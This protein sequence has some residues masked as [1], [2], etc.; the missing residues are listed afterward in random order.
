MKIVIA[1]DSFKESLSSIEVANAIEAGFRRVFPDA[2]YVSLPVADGGEGTAEALIYASNGQRKCTQV[3]DPIFR[4]VGAEWGV[5][6]NSDTAVIE[7]AAASGLKMLPTDLRN[8]AVTSSFGSGELILAGLDEGF[9]HFIIGLGGSASNDCGAGLLSALGARFL[10]SRGRPVRDGGYY[11]K[12]V[13]TVDLSALDIRLKDCRF[14]IA[15]DVDNT[16]VGEN[17][18]SFIFGPQKGASQKLVKQLDF[19]VHHFASKLEKLCGR[20]LI[21]IPGSGA[22]GGIAAAFLALGGA[23]IVSGIDLVLDAIDIDRYL[24]G[25]D[26]VLTGEGKLDSQ[27]LRGKVPVGVARR[28]RQYGIPVVVLAGA[29]E[30]NLRDLYCE[31]I[32]SAF[33]VVPGICNLEQAINSAREN[34]ANT[35]ENV[36]RMWAFSPRTD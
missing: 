22:A 6:G 9:C 36:A 8:P 21:S 27:S 12:D 7:I 26:L 35:A 11:L 4:P 5:L 34:V 23:Q 33:S 2:E 30:G 31:G 14:D 24:K 20:D 17:G 16:L 32:A 29:L 10:D 15:C 25:A 18:A 13:E 3:N 28:A 19:A 1:P